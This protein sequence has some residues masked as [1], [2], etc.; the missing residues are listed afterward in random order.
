MKLWINGDWWCLRWGLTNGPDHRTREISR[1]TA[2]LAATEYRHSPRGQTKEQA[3][4]KRYWAAEKD[5]GFQAFKALI[6][7]LVVPKRGRKPA[8]PQAGAGQP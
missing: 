5:K 6:P 8:K 1:L 7:A 4:W 3:R 2:E